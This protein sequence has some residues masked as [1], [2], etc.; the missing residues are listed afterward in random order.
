[1]KKSEL[2][3]MVRKIVREEVALAINEV[4]TELK[5]PSQQPN[6][7]KKINNDKASFTSNSVL[8]DVLN[9]T[10]MADEWKT[11]GGGSYTS[12]KVNEIPSSQNGSLM[13]GLSQQN[14]S[15]NDPMSGFLNKD[16]RGVMKKVDNIVKQKRG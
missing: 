9:E 10:A 1:M 7:V 13:N 8:N 6:K 14:V 11:L 3:I 12:D 5:T 4:I 16:Y 15:S 2:K